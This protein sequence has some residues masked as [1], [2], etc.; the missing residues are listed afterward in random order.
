MIHR[1]DN[2]SLYSSDNGTATPD[3]YHHLLERVN[4]TPKRSREHLNK[5]NEQKKKARHEERYHQQQIIS[6]S[7]KRNISLQGTEPK[8]ISSNYRSTTTTTS[9]NKSYNIPMDQL[10]RAVGCNLP[11]FVIELD[12]SIATRNLPSAIIACDLIKD[13]FNKINI[14]I[15]DFSV[16]IFVGH[17][18]KLGVN[19][20]EDYSK[21]V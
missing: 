13:H 6:Q 2:K 18:L 3:N 4:S 17:R 9:I 5:S 19:N 11:C 20:M 7:P 10:Q 14:G 21:L 15:N 8:M 1:I 12:N 16:A